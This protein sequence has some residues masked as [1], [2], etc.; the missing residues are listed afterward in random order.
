MQVIQRTL[1]TIITEQILES[2]LKDLVDRAGAEGYSVTSPVHGKGKHGERSGP[3]DMRD[4]IKMVL[5]VP[6][7]IAE[8]ILRTI[9]KEYGNTFSILAFMH[10]VDVVQWTPTFTAPR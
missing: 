3:A 7:E 4:N 10:D 6:K 8:T 1:L 5:V 9:E 2:K